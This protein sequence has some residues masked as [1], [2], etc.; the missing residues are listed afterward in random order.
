[1][2]LIESAAE[3]TIKN[4]F[5]D[6]TS[7]GFKLSEIQ[8][9]NYH[10]EFSVL[11]GKDRIKLQVY[12]GK[13]GAK[14]VLQGDNTS[15]LYKELYQKFNT[16]I[17]AFT[18]QN[19]GMETEKLIE[20]SCYI[21]TDESGKGDY[22]GPLVIA[23]VVADESNIKIL[24]LLGV[25]DSK[26]LSDSLIKKISHEIKIIENIKFNIISIYPKKY[27][28]LYT[29]IGNLNGILG[30]AHA[31]VIENLLEKHEVKEAI[32]DKFGN[33]KYIYASLQEKGQNIT[34][35]QVTKAER[36]IAVA[37]ASILA[38][39]RFNS[40]FMH[41][42]QKLGLELP[43]GASENCELAAIEIMKKI[44]DHSLK[45]FV[46]LHFKNTQRLNKN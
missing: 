10:Y 45:D 39:N 36:Y 11:R 44:G 14:T 24:K 26:E 18:S 28:E 35:H 33:E 25:K 19:S 32:S 12:F 7:Q 30:W 1:L 41:E 17:F 6:L 31:K 9:Q 16:D 34:L 2:N 22:F 23:G 29:R 15:S 38:R 8:R 21:G 5:D 43:K 42:K 3:R 27:N 20:P 13:K 37:A 40:W 4:Y 46:K